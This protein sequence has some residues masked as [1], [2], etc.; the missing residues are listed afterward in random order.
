MDRINPFE[1]QFKSISNTA[2]LEI[3]ENPGDFQP[4]AIA[5]AKTELANRALSP[6]EIIEAKKPLLEKKMVEEKKSARVK[7]AK[8]MI[9]DTQDTL[10]D[11]LNPVLW[12][13]TSTGKIILLIGIVFGVTSIY[14]LVKSAD[15]II[16]YLQYLAQ[17]PLET[18]LLV[19]PLLVLP[20]AV[21]GFL[22][23]KPLGWILLA[24]YLSFS[25]I[26]ITWTFLHS[27]RWQ[28]SGL[29]A[30]DKVFRHP[31]PL[32]ILIQL[33]ILSGTLYAICSYD[34]R[35]IYRIDKQKMGITIIL[36]ALFSL[37]LIMAIS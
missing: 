26:S 21:V 15:E 14:S 27:I 28:P 4:E 22:I 32:V 29:T 37:A 23:R 5:A 31:S 16:F 12:N 34:I 24:T 36:S 10:A 3:L 13:K 8:K 19:F 9:R 25:I 11:T 30:A 18:V 1:E 2:L 20:V 6:E 17:Y 35:M 7:E 33:L